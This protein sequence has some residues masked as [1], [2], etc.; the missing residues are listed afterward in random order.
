MGDN[1]VSSRVQ[2][3]DRLGLHPVHDRRRNLAGRRTHGVG[4]ERLLWLCVETELEEVSLKAGRL[5]S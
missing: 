3:I 1:E 2:V 5:F 4:L